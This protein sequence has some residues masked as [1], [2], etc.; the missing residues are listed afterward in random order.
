LYED[1]DEFRR[2]LDLYKQLGK[3]ADVDRLRRRVPHDFSDIEELE[4]LG[5]FTEAGDVAA[6]GRY[7]QKQLIYSS[8]PAKTNA[9]LRP[10]SS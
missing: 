5:Q 2:A 10:C 1:A 3:R 7:A 4:K 6:S 8:A 9:N